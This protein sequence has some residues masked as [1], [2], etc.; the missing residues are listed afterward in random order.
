MENKLTWGLILVNF[1]VFEILFSLPL[2][3]REIVVELLSFSYGTSFEAWRWVTSMFV[4]ANAS[5][6]F[7]NML[8]LYFFGK[9]LEE[10]IS[11]QWYIAIYFIGGFMGS[12]VFMFSNPSPVIGASGAMFAVMGAAMFLNPVKKIHIYVIP[13]TSGIVAIFFVIV[14]TF[15]LYMQPD[16]GNVA[17]IAHI[18]G[19]A[20]G[21][22]FAFFHSPKKSLKGM[23]LLGISLALIVI[24]API[25]GFITGIG[26]IILQVLDLIIGFVLYGI[27]N[28]ISVIWV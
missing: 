6:F 24:L 27:A 16:F 18:G 15:I 23:I 11:K 3:S 28:A 5:H 10:E 9:I 4:H 21:A 13:L 1:I 25:F 14:E 20:T 17:H 22:I 7:F 26:G 8:G 12:F 2:A 19:L